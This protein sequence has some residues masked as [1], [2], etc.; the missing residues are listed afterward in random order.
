MWLQMWRDRG[1]GQSWAGIPR[2]AWPQ[3]SKHTCSERAFWTPNSSARLEPCPCP[4]PDS[5]GSITVAL[6]HTLLW[7]K[8][9]VQHL[10]EKQRGSRGRG[11]GSCRTLPELDR[12]VLGIA[13]TQTQSQGLP[14]PSALPCVCSH[15][16]SSKKHAGKLQQQ[17]ILRCCCWTMQQNAASG[18]LPWAFAF[19]GA[20]H[21]GPS[22]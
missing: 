22:P 6:Q 10:K 13:N 12:F 7:F 1:E 15:G 14:Q 3:Q 4:C 21:S 19:S 20:G 5:P 17:D 9:S 16:H 11:E 18:D 2:A 8:A